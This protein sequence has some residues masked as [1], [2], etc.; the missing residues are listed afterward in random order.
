M[1]PLEDVLAL[2]RF[3]D[4]DREGTLWLDV[5]LGFTLLLFCFCEEE[6]GVPVPYSTQQYNLNL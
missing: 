5:E 3:I 2:V 4:L 1:P 6:D